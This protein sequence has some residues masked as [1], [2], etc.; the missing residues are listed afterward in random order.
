MAQVDVVLK[1]LSLHHHL[2]SESMLSFSKQSIVLLSISIVAI[3]A[4]EDVCTG[5]RCDTQA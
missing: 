3:N 1:A 5:K 2:G 4:A